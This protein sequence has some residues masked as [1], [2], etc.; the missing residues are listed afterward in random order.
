[1][2]VPA[3]TSPIEPVVVG[4]D[5]SASSLEAVELAAREAVLR[6]RP[7][8]VV[9]AFIWPYLHVP[10]GPSPYGPPEGGLR[11]QAES[12]L[13][14]AGARARA[15]APDL[16]V[17]SEIVSGEAAAVLVDASRTAELI[18]VGDR[19]LGGFTG[20]L[21]GS[22]AVQLAA[23]ATCPILVA[24]G[25]VHP[26]A[27]VLLGVDG[28]P[29]NDPAV[30]FA[31]EEAALRGVP[32]VAMH[33]WTH[34]VSTGPGDMLPL[35]YDADELM[36]EEAR[37]LAEA[38][39]GWHDKYPGVVVRRELPHAGARGALIEATHRAQLVVVGTRGRGGLSGLLLGS[40]SQAVLHHAAC[41]VAVVPH[42]PTAE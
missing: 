14:E 1:M 18:V 33:A 22:V 5:G 28:S 15:A 40:V 30:G 13:A 21:I 11:H 12:L 8:R 37:V 26:A 7:L 39:A 19:G 32:L 4:V 38:L 24:R 23:H 31:F 6:R 10:L 20:L 42:E 27:P 36:A 9:H 3:H 41:P 2:A 35:V 17:D 29:A 34:P 25:G 16:A